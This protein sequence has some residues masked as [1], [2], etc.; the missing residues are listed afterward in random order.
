MF[1][2]LQNLTGMHLLKTQTSGTYK[3]AFFS[4]FLNKPNVLTEDK[5]IDESHIIVFFH[6]YVH[7]LQDLF[8]NIGLRNIIDLIHEYSVI[9]NEILNSDS[10]NFKIPYK[11]INEQLLLN[12]TMGNLIMGSSKIYYED[13]DFGIVSVKMQPNLLNP[14][15][16]F[17]FIAV[18][19]LYKSTLEEDE[20]YL[21]ANHFLENM[22][23][24][25][26][27][28]LSFEDDAPPF[29]Y[30]VVEKIIKCYFP[31]GDLSSE[32]LITVMEDAL[33]T[34]DPARYLHQ[35]IEI[36]TTHDVPFNQ[37]N[38]VSF[39]KNY[40]LTISG[41]RVTLERLFFENATEARRGFKILFAHNNLSVV[42][43]WAN[44]VISHVIAMKRGGFSFRE[45]LNQGF[46]Q[47]RI[48]KRTSAIIRKLGTPL[49]IDRKGTLFYNPPRQEFALGMQYLM[50]LEAIISLLRGDFTCAAL[51]I[52]R[53]LLDGTDLTN[54]YC[55]SA[56]W[57]RAKQMPRC[58]I[59]QLWIMWGFV[60]K[61]VVL[62]VD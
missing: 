52:C 54:E 1:V 35:M 59:G 62:A 46:D 19:I 48:L 51:Q 41:R 57:E 10:P 5:K 49:I 45:L 22:A 7:F 25:L 11:T 17:D 61:E 13:Q 29:P 24:L 56:P 31:D 44:H 3:P 50:G 55:R 9:N 8:T 33:Q 26:E 30:K 20:F 36:F 58:I 4:I 2:S 42:K 12:A 47:D 16:P 21:G 43:D 18:K 39:A 53:N 60:K 37:T 34:L 23:H 28:S 40:K 38:I 15:L 14:T 27:R 32:N 6:E